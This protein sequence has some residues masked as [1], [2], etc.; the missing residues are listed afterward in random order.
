MTRDQRRCAVA[1]CSIGASNCH[2]SASAMHAGGIA[3]KLPQ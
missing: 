1:Q 2:L 3:A